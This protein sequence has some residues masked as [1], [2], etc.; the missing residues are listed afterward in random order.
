RILRIQAAEIADQILDHGQVRQRRQA[1]RAAAQ[2]TDVSDAGQLGG[3]VDVHGAGAAHAFAAGAAHGDGGVDFVD[4][5]QD[6]IE[7][8]RPAVVEIDFVAAHA[9][10]SVGGRIV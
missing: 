10:A 3:A 2:I 7:H 9:R 5:L 8:H 6:G 1:N 4:D